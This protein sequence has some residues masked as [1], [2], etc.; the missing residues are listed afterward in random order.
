MR[1]RPFR[2]VYHF[3]TRQVGRITACSSPE[4]VIRSVA[5]RVFSGEVNLVYV[6][7]DQDIFAIIRSTPQGVKLEVK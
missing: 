4:G 1:N 7:L 2:V 5:V 3:H 6:Y